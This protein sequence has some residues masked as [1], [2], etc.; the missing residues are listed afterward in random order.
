MRRF[1][2]VSTVAASAALAALLTAPA[3]ASPAVPAVPPTPPGV[4][5]ARQ[6]LAALTVAA[7]GSMDGY[8]RAKFPHWIT[9]SGQCN[10]RETA[11][12]RDGEEVETDAKC[13][14]IS[15]RWTSPY[16]GAT[17]TRASDLDIDHMVPLAQAWRSGASAWTTARRK[18]FANDLKSSQLWTVT[19]NVNQAKGDKDPGQWKPP[20]TS[21]YCM[22]ARSWIDVKWRYDLSADGA[23][24]AALLSMLDR[25]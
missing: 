23:E 17:W 5:E 24:K 1:P 14:A 21:F 8:S 16:D 12:K 6:H 11:L 13:A 20:L 7:E 25:C 2:V 19:D 22:Y 10:T 9:I 18:Q 3:N 15:G 4:G